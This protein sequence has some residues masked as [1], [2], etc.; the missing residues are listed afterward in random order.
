MKKILIIGD[1]WGV[2][3]DRYIP[4]SIEAI[5]ATGPDFFLEQKGYTVVNR[6]EAGASNLTQLESIESIDADYVIW[7]HTE[8]NRDLLSR[9]L[10]GNNFRQLTEQAAENN[11]KLA[12][13][14]YDKFKVP[15]IVI[16]CLSPLHKS[17]EKYSFYKYKIDSWLQ[18]LS[19]FE[20]PLNI[21]SDNM[22]KVMTE[23]PPSDKTFVIDEIDGMLSVESALETHPAF[24]QGVHPSKDSYQQLVDRLHLFIT[25]N[26]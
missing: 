8:T 10:A 21:H 22:D 5:P 23:Y 11:Y 6:A 12:Q 14:L 9:K 19:G 25:A 2:G 16:G 17:I 3:A 24:S 15:F 26:N 4:K 20:P 13:A 18:E 7:F 1:S